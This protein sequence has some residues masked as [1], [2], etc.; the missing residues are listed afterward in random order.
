MNRPANRNHS[1]AMRALSSGAAC[2]IAFALTF[3]IVLIV[4]T[5]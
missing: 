5:V 1:C 4:V 2:G 3:V